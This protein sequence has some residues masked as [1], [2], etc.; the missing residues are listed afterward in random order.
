M[1]H[2]HMRQHG[3]V[4]VNWAVTAHFAGVTGGKKVTR[5]GRCGKPVR[6][7]CCRDTPISRR[8]ARQWAAARE[9]ARF[10]PLEP[11]VVPR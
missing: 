5:D 6:L 9:F 7:S 2:C 8:N 4:A 10:K 1:V 11:T 3:Q